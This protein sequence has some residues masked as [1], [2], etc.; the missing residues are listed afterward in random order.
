MSY[1]L[2]K[3]E[4]SELSISDLAGRP[5]RTESWDGVRNY[6]ARNIL[7]DGMKPG[8][9]AFFYH[10]SCAEPGIVGIA[11]VASP[12]R[13]D[14]TQFQAGHRHHDPDSDP[15]NPRW[16]L[17]DVQLVRKLRRTITLNELKAHPA[18]AGMPLLRRGNRLSVMPLSATEWDAI[19]GLE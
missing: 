11:R 15:A 18:I 6:Q 7:R 4:P 8:D 16:Y 19:L 1:W 12:A 10:S 13:P 17:V 3:S 5:A 2:L 14:P 9:L